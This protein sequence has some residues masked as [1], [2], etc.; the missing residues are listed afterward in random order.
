MTEWVG[1][2]R[3]I[4]DG[5]EEDFEHETYPPPA[6]RFA[7]WTEQIESATADTLRLWAAGGTG[8][9]NYRHTEI[10]TE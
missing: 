4:P 3:P 8:E 5:L 9:A 7:P 1:E 10:G 6:T 2:E